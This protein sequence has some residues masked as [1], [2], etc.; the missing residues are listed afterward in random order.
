MPFD[1]EPEWTERA[2][3]RGLDPLGLQTA[4]I[5]LYQELLPGI[6]NVTLRMRPY[7][8]YAWLTEAYARH[9]GGD[10]DPEAWRR[11]VRRTEALYAL[12]AADAGGETGV[13][14]VEWAAGCLK[15]HAP[16]AVIDFA[17]A[18]GTTGKGL[19][20]QQSMGVYGG[21]Y[22]SQMVEMGLLGHADDERNQI[23]VPTPEIGL[24]LARAFAES[25]GPDRE[26]LILAAIDTPRVRRSDLAVLHDVLP[27][28][29]DPESSEADLYR[30]VLFG[31]HDGAGERDN[32]RCRSLQLILTITGRIAARPTPDQVR[33]ALYNAEPGAFGDALEADRLRWEAYQT[34]DLLQ[35]AFAALLRLSVDELRTGGADLTFRELVVAS[36]NKTVDAFPGA[37]NQTW[38][39]FVAGQTDVDVAPLARALAR[40]PVGGI[41][42]ESIAGALSM[43]GTLQAR[44]DSRPDLA[45]E[46]EVVFPNSDGRI[47]ARSIRSELA[48][49]RTN[50]DVG[51]RDMA[52]QLFA[53]R[54]IR[55]HSEVAMLKFARQRDY[56][57]LFEAT[58]GRLRYR[59][60][61]GPVLTTPRLGP[62]ITFLADLRLLDGGGLTAR[63][64]DWL[65]EL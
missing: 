45:A 49:L 55:R 5:F 50:N 37:G 39:E 63:G 30:K 14:G 43:I 2:N 35:L 1:A 56:T 16:D 65:A 64:Q 9:S 7:G 47:F 4:G 54:I 24:P 59:A 62:A 3:K 42:R 18:T 20:L 44:V 26:A 51:I 12:V 32:A 21:A 48:F 29:I 13:A 17:A 33:W 61:Y 58:D 11:W 6:S 31:A 52:P 25:L 36:S 23:L 38:S 60:D 53:D 19:Y 8:L 46:I 15:A 41:S 22:G 34:H 28:R 27:G 57:F 40:I 10:T